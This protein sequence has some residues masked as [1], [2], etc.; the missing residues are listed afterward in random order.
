MKIKSFMKSFVKGFEILKNHKICRYINTK[1]FILHLNAYRYRE[2]MADHDDCRKPV[3]LP[4]CSAFAV[5]LTQ[6]LNR[7]FN[8]CI[9]DDFQPKAAQIVTIDNIDKKL[10]LLSKRA[11][12]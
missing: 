2:E 1:N 9:I 10:Q 3:F 5:V 8:V 12:I 7:Q 6:I 4:L 11:G